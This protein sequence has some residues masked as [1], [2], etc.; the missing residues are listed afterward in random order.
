MKLRILSCFLIFALCFSMLSACGSDTAPSDHSPN[1][2]LQTEISDSQDSTPVESSETDPA[3]TSDDDS[4]EGEAEPSQVV[5]PATPP[6]QQAESSAPAEITTASRFSTSDVPAYS[7]K[8]YTSVN[9]NVPYF[10]AAELATQSFETY[11]DLDS[12]GRCGVTYACIGKDLMPTEERGSI[13]MVKPTGWHTVRYDDLVDGKYL[14]NRCHLIGYQLTGENANTKNLITGTRYLNIEG[15]YFGVNKLTGELKHISEV[16]SGQKC[17]CICAACLQPFEARKGTRRRHHFAHVSNYECMYASEVAIYKAFA[18]ALKQSGFLT[19]SPVMLRFPAWHD[20]ELLQEARRL[21][22]DSVAF[23]CE[24]LSYPP[25]LRVTMQG[26]PLRIL[27]DFDRYYDDDDRVELAEE[28]KAEDYSLL[29]ISMPKIEQ[30]TEFTPD[31]L[32]SALQDNDRTEWV[33]SRLEEQWKQ[34]Y[35]AVAVSPPEHGTG[36]LCPISFGKYKGKYS[37]RWI[38][39]AHC[40][41][42]VAQPP[43]CLCVAGAGIQKKEDFKR[44]LQDRLFDIDKIRRTNEEEIRLREERE[45]SFERRSVYPRPTPYAARPVVPAGPTQEELDAEYIRICQSYDPTSDEWTVDRYNRRWI[46]CTVC[47]RIK[48]DTQ[49]SYYGGKGGANR[50][51]CADCSRNGRS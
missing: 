25:L 24:P 35:Y 49:M 7:G 3:G 23:E 31:R 51:V 26:T 45:R 43:C 10:S 27:L 5:E 19:L 40:H 28:A 36:N 12:L 44:D 14:Y 41:F 9:G 47:G 21:K 18:E 1:S 37:A 39:C 13:G 33:F 6:D 4:S 20:P 34:K 38:D 48:Q 16:P 2:S 30:D 8:A 17:N 15:I 46:M 11:S 29:L 22:I 42:N 50:G 32:Q